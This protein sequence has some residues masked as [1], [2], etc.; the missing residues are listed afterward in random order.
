MFYVMMYDEDWLRSE[1][2]GQ[3]KCSL[4]QLMEG[5]EG[6]GKPSPPTWCVPACGHQHAACFFHVCALL[7]HM[8]AKACVLCVHV[9]VGAYVLCP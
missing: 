2:M 7:K 3:V 5:V 6:P 1:F 8:R 9:H 4:G